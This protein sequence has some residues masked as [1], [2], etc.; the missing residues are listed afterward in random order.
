MADLAATIEEY[1]H[2]LAAMPAPYRAGGR[3]MS[4]TLIAYHE[5][6]TDLVQ[7][8]SSWPPSCSLS[9]AVRALQQRLG[10]HGIS[11]DRNKLFLADRP[12]LDRVRRAV[13]KR[14]AN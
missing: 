5:S 14:S 6:R 3:A 13:P 9:A 2:R 4:A 10:P 12:A 1:R 7:T 8:L 11:A